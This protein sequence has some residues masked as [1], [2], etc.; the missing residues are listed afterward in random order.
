M[1]FVTCLEWGKK[2]KS[3]L[4]A[5]H[6]TQLVGC[7]RA[8]NRMLSDVSPSRDRFVALVRSKLPG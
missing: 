6:F 1:V 2:K 5:G 3:Q 8:L 7:S 4:L